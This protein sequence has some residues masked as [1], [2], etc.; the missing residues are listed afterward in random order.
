MEISVVQFGDST[1]RW[2]L[3]EKFLKTRKQV[4]IDRMGWNLVPHKAIECDQYDVISAAT[5]VIAHRGDEILGG[6]RLLRCDSKIGTGQVVYS[7]MIRDAWRGII[8]IPPRHL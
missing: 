8:D 7:Y 4:F 5:Y 6:A 3:A 1:S 2:D